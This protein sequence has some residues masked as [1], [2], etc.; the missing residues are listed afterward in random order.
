MKIIK[1]LRRKEKGKLAGHLLAVQNLIRLYITES[2]NVVVATKLVCCD[3]KEREGLDY[4]ILNYVS[5]KLSESIPENEELLEATYK[6][7]YTEGVEKEISLDDE[8]YYEF[9]KL[10]GEYITIDK[11]KEIAS[12]FDKKKEDL[13]TLLEATRII[14]SVEHG[15]EFIVKK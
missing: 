8:S 13:E 15:E 11:I 3:S 10:L 4:H 5:L 6:L 2:V 12:T 9:L 14:N 1:N 7:I